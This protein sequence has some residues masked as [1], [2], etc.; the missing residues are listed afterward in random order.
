MNN[1][2]LEKIAKLMVTPNKGILAADESTGTIKKRL[3]SIGLESNEA[4]RRSYRELLFSTP[5]IE[6]YISGVIL[7]DET[8]R[9]TN[10]QGKK[11]LTVL[12]DKN[13]IPGIK[14]DKGT[15]PCPG[16]NDFPFTQGL[17]GLK[18]RCDEYFDLGAK[19]T[20]WRAVIKIIESFI[21]NEVIQTNA[22]ALALYAATA[23]ESGLVPIV[24]P[25]VLMDGA[26]NME[27]CEKITLETLKLVFSE[28]DKYN[29]NL[30]AI[31]LKPNMILP[32]SESNE[33][34]SCSEIAKK[35]LSVL[36]EC[37]PE[38]V[39]GIAFLSGGQTEI[40]AT[41]NLNSMNISRNLPWEL[42]FSYGRALQHST[43]NKWRGKQE[44]ILESQKIFIH[45][46]TMNSLAHGGE[47]NSSLE[48]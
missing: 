32:G 3:E 26:H 4:N 35:T 15:F 22:Q 45:R 13:I 24:E 39:P 42:T 8:L 40:E 5:E 12:E 20:K 38:D 34:V 33:I 23:Q 18:Q 47:Y 2:T 1:S 43:L 41:E 11:L 25:E 37:V 48:N 6:K 9:Q 29:V 36:K 14:V 31:V 17:D 16:H 44:N 19:F 21:P 7:F 27:T 30:R 28:L 10:N 46:A